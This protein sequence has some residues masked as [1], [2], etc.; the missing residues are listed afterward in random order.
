METTKLG[1][2]GTSR[3][4]DLIAGRTDEREAPKHRPRIVERAEDHGL[5]ISRDLVRHTHLSAAALLSQRHQLTSLG[6]TQI[7]PNTGPPPSPL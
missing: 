5:E 6:C 1:F 7:T 2:P 3:L 4:N